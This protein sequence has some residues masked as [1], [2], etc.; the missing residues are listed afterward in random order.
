MAQNLNQ[1]QP[2]I[3]NPPQKKV[4]WNLPPSGAQT[5]QPGQY[6]ATPSM[7]S[8]TTLNASVPAFF[9]PQQY[10]QVT[11][12]PPPP[13]H[14]VRPAIHPSYIT[15]NPH[16]APPGLEGSDMQYSS[17]SIPPV[18]LGPAAFSYA[19]LQQQQ[20]QQQQ[21]QQPSFDGPKPSQ[22]MEFKRRQQYEQ[23]LQQ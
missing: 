3:K 7:L 23:Q 12:S 2:A 18:P 1:S 17:T 19:A 9:P 13:P 21:Q 8:G 22:Y 11:P 5:P 14:I 16:M 6:S 4:T 10:Q 15:S 20:Y